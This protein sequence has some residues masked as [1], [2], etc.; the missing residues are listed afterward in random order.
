MPRPPL[1]HRWFVQYNPLFFASALS[2]LGGVF[3]LSREL[4]RDAFPSK[5]GIVASTEIYQL[6]LIAG[7]AILLRAGLRRPAALLGITALVFLLDVALNGERLI[8]HAGP[9]SFEPGM[10]ARR[11]VPASLAFALLGPV[12]VWLL[13]RVFRLRGAA[14]ALRIAGL[15]VLALPL[16][17][18]LTEIAGAGRREA[19]HLA[20]SWFGA[21]LLAW[22][23]SDGSR[24]WTSA[25]LDGVEDPRLRRLARLA[26]FLVTGFFLFHTVLW[27]YAA[28]LS[29]S[30]AQA[31]PFV[32]V[33]LGTAAW[34]LAAIDPLR[35]E[36]AAW[37]GSGL[38][39][40]CA[41]LAPPETGRWPI[42]AMSCAA[43]VLLIMLVELKGLRL[44]LP[45]A[46]CIFGAAYALS[47]QAA[48]RLPAPGPAW[49]AGLAIAL[50]AGAIRQRDFRCLVA[51]A[52][53]AGM[54]AA[55][56]PPVEADP[57]YGGMIGGA[58][59]AVG[60]W[61][62][63][64]GLRRWVP[65]AATGVV[66]TIGA[67][68]SWLGH[69]G[70]SEATVV[71][72]AATIGLGWLARRRDFQVT[73]VSAGAALAAVRHEAWTPHTTGGWGMFLLAAGFVFL[74]AG[75]AI[76]LRL[77]RRRS[78]GTFPGA[79]VPAALGSRARDGHPSS[80]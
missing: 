47:T 30:F 36:L 67:G 69:P 31:A 65:L 26:P 25:W 50:L 10:R 58:W 20:V 28:S 66:L 43:G 27:G 70:M 51:S 73:G 8:S 7:A 29:R 56:L 59:L 44:F 16:L 57:G 37:V 2:V 53:S 17:P 19:A 35:A 12:K 78:G 60:S 54:A 24:R 13:A 68:M 76:N 62:L 41:V 42:A 6:L 61:F 9:I 14:A 72:A 22:A 32:L 46:V 39:L 49:P 15:A 33:L 4:P 55:I 79:E 40:A 77:A 38:T 71:L 48:G 80:P 74:S 3:L 11:V 18:Y 63:F 75:I 64:P 21:P 34:R 45:A 23:L 52:L 1:L 5:L